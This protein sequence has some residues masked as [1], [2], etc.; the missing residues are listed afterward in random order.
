M[1]R[2]DISLY[3]HLPWCIEKCPY[4]DFNSFKKTDQDRED[5][6]TAAICQ[7]IIASASEAQGRKLKSIFFGGG[8]PSLFSVKNIGMILD[9]IS[10]HYTLGKQCEITLEMNPSSFEIEKMAGFCSLGINRLSIGVQSLHDHLLKKIGRTH[11]KKQAIAAIKAALQQPFQSV[12]VDLMYALPEQTLAE[13]MEDLQQVIDLGPGHLSWYELTIEA[14]TYFA[15]HHPKLPSDNTQ[16]QIYEQGLETLKSQGYHRYEISAFSCDNRPSQHNLNYW[17]FG[18]Y[19]GCGNGA[20]SKITK[21]D[22]VIRYQKYRNPG[23][24]QAEPEKKVNHTGVGKEDMIFEYML[25]KLRLMDGFSIQEVKRCTQLP[26]K[27]IIDKLS[28]AVEQGYLRI[29]GSTIIQTEKGKLFMND[30]QALFI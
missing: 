20:S 5:V 8:T 24:Y 1:S 29:D 10:T 11:N 4:C 7:D 9:V 30:C 12:N 21:E 27:F 26:E 16:Y 22:T 15:K 23:L 2:P 3:C 28:S 18:D 6:Y 17:N 25:N 14:N 13:A 19:I